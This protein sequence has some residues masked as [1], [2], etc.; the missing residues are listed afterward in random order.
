MTQ[1]KEHSW[2]E[3]DHENRHT[4]VWVM[5][6]T[7]TSCW[8]ITN[9]ARLPFVS[10]IDACLD[11]VGVRQSYRF[12]FGGGRLETRLQYWKFYSGLP[13]FTPVLLNKNH[14]HSFIILQSDY[15]EP[16]YC[17]RFSTTRQK[18]YCTSCSEL[19][20]EFN[21]ASPLPVPFCLHWLHRCFPI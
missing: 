15:R 5:M 9:E 12:T 10:C 19:N 14:H 11:A 16:H 21:F 20:T 7:S 6:L 18:I 3:W 17:K 2:N 8:R 4:P 1:R 13:W